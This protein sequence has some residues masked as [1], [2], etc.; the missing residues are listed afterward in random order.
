MT[1]CTS[2][3]C[4]VFVITCQDYLTFLCAVIVLCASPDSVRDIMIQAHDLNFDNGEYV[5][6]NIDLFNRYAS[7]NTRHAY[8][9]RFAFI[10]LNVFLSAFE[11]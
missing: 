8:H 3:I 9:V 1:L 10:T 4:H 11:F 5:F 7:S 6:L 2:D